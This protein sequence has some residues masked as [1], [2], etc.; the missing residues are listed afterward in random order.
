[1]KLPDHTKV[2]ERTNVIVGA[3][4][5][6]PSLVNWGPQK[7]A[8]YLRRICAFCLN[9][10]ETPEGCNMKRLSYAPECYPVQLSCVSDIWRTTPWEAPR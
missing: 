2:F 8:D 5:T 6:A 7:E 10:L 4:A 9:N 3:Y 1:M